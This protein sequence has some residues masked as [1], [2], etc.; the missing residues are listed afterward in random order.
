MTGDVAGVD[1]V[2]ALAGGG[3]LPLAAPMPS[4]VA[5]PPSATALLNRCDAL[6]GEVG[7]RMHRF[8]WLREPGAPIE[9]C[10]VVDAYY[11]GNRVVVI[12]GEHTE[13]ESRLCGEQVPAHGLRLLTLNPEHFVD[14]TAQITRRLSALIGS[15][16]PARARPRERVLPPAPVRTPSSV[17]TGSPA[18]PRDPEPT[19]PLGAARSAAARARSAPVPPGQAAASGRTS[20]EQRERAGIVLGLALVVIVVAE[21][22]IFV[23]ILG[24]GDGNPV[25]AIGFA[26]DVCARVLGTIAFTRDGDDERAWACLIVGSPAVVNYTLLAEEVVAT[27]PAPLGG[28]LGVLACVLVVFGLFGV[29][30][31]L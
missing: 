12:C 11:P 16:G 21:L 14:E 9:A 1:P 7:R 18:P 3:S 17:R 15:L 6:L 24:F 31:G 30:I 27:E 4:S 8:A 25:L 29:L 5:V 19:S 26:L 23:A 2:P 20:D 28:A 10:M 13:Q 22:M